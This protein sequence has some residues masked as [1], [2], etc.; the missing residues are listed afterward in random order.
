M[1]LWSDLNSLTF[2]AQSITL[3]D[4]DYD[5]LE[6]YYATSDNVKIIT[7]SSCKVLKGFSITLKD[8]LTSST[9]I[10]TALRNIT[11][12]SDTEL[13]VGNCVRGDVVEN[14]FQYKTDNKRIYPYKI[15][16]GK[17]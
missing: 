17:F 9:Y 1:L 6:V 7:M 12:V 15:Y 13:S 11:F 10:G 14:T 3:S 16:G 5:Y 2:A 4:S 8:V